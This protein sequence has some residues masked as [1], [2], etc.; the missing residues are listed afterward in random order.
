MATRVLVVDDQPFM[1]MVVK[2]VLTPNGFEVVGEAADGKAAIE[3]FARLKPDLVTLDVVMPNLDGLGALKEIRKLDPH[4][5]VL[6]VTSAGQHSMVQEALRQ[7]AVGYVTKPF[8]APQMLQA[9]RQAL[10]ATA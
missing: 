5:R 4:A 8:Q 1:R 10:G 2:N 6:M 7:G 9:V 3:A